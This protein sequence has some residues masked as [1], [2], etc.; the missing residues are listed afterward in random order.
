MFRALVGL[1]GGIRR[2]V[3]CDLGAIHC[4][5]R[6]LGWEK[7]GHGFSSRPRESAS[8]GFF[9]EQL[10]LFGYPSGSAAALLGGELPL[11]YC[12]GKFS[13][14]VPTWGLPAR[15]QLPGLVGDAGVLRDRRILGRGGVKS[16]ATQKNPSTPCRIW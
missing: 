8:E 12:S 15:A 2:F 3:S 7:C 6:H 5:L 10:V 14:R 16:S 1:P 4:R 13:S 9:G 11:R